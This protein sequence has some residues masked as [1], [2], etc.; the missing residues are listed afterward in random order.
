MNN[1]SD[2]N[3]IHRDVLEVNQC[4][5]EGKPYL[6][7]QRKNR[8]SVFVSKGIQRGFTEQQLRSENPHLEDKL[9]N[10]TEFHS[11]AYYM[12][13]YML[14]AFYNFLS[15]FHRMEVGNLDIVIGS[16]DAKSKPTV[17][18]SYYDQQ[19]NQWL[20]MIDDVVVE[21]EPLRTEGDLASDL[22]YFDKEEPQEPTQLELDLKPKLNVV[23]DCKKD[24]E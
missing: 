8:D 17:E 13:R 1:I 24:K 7:R 23:K 2:H 3:L 21:H 4:E 22:D 16:A 20:N 9:F 10:S 5:I 19:G 18:V 15:D 12:K 11:G 6:L 14:D